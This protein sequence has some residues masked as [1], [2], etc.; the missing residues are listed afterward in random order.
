MIVLYPGPKPGEEE[1][2]RERSTR[3]VDYLGQLDVTRTEHKGC[4]SHF[5]R[6]RFL[7]QPEQRKPNL[8]DKENDGR[9]QKGD[10]GGRES[11][12]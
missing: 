7:L 10:T 12:K 2:R 3:R 4:D 9:A 1:N 11:W 8:G 6:I 5:G